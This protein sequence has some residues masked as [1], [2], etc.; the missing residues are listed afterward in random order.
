[1]VPSRWAGLENVALEGI[2]SGTPTLCSTATGLDELP[3]DPSLTFFA[4]EPESLARALEAVL[5][6]S[7]RERADLA[8]AQRAF[9]VRELDQNRIAARFE[10]FLTGAGL[11]ERR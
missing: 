8:R 4:L 11:L 1:M 10:E 3:A 9:I 7:P 5:A 2:L 6:K